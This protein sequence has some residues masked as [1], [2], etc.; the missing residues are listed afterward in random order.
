MHKG[1]D[2]GVRTSS[3]VRWSWSLKTS[4]RDTPTRGTCL[5]IHAYLSA[6]MCLAL[7]LSSGS[8][9]AEL[10]PIG[11]LYTPGISPFSNSFYATE[12]DACRAATTVAGN[13][14]IFS[15]TEKISGRW[16][17]T[18][19]ACIFKD[20][21]GQLLPLSECFLNRLAR[22]TASL[23]GCFPFGDGPTHVFATKISLKI[24]SATYAFLTRV[25]NRKKR[26]FPPSRLRSAPRAFKHLTPFF[27]LP[28][29][30]FG[31]NPIS[32]APDRRLFHLLAS[33]AALGAQ[34]LRGRQGRWVKLGPTT[35]PSL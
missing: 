24:L 22:Q 15:H 35:T 30:S 33:I 26:H 18:A 21:Q 4:R 25:G 31:S 7:L 17:G 2:A 9:N 1:I 8:V 19:S 28:L 16:S 34:M 6:S 11:T 20:A 23:D 12:N 3:L 10:Q 27:P 5:S 14:R 13:G 29:T 32:Q